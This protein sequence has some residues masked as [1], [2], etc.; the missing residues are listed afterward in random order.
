M[1]VIVTVLE[2]VGRAPAQGWG[3]REI[4]LAAC[5]DTSGALA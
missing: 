5:K 2:L 3:L 4:E 1:E